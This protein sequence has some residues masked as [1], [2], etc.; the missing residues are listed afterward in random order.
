MTMMSDLS[1][2]LVGKILYKVPIASLRAVRSTCKQW[3]ALSKDA[4]LCKAEAMQPFLG[5]MMMNYKLCSIRFDLRG[6]SNKEGSAEYFVDPSIKEIGNLINQV[7]ITKAFHCD[8]LLLCVSRDRTRLV[9]CNPYLCQTKWIQPLNAYHRLDRY[10]IGYDND[11]NHKILRFLDHSD[12]Y[13]KHKFLEYE[14]FDLRSNS[15][16]VLDI[17]PGWEIEFYQR[18]VSLKGN[19]YFFA[20]EKIVYE[21]DGTYPEPPDYLLC[22]D[23]TTESFGQFLPLPFVHYIEHTGTLSYVKG[24]K[25]AALYQNMDTCELEIWVTTMIEPNA[26]SWSNFFKVDMILLTGL[27]FQFGVES[28]SFFIDEEKKVAVVFD[29]DE[30]ESYTTAYIIGE[31]RYLKKVN[32]GEAFVNLEESPYGRPIVSTYYVPSL[33]DIS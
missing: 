15:W 25:L 22:F 27:D 3:N 19:T 21:G 5:F 26:V 10:A 9:V 17:T 32:L 13:V 16:R 30:S 31:N 14:I 1:Q 23:F 28:G 7:D 8:G 2:V 6:I 4:V 20:K 18:G 11:G 24:E 12:P 29:L 33:V